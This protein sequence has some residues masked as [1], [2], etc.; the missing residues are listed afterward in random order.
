MVKFN[1]APKLRASTQFL[2]EQAYTINCMQRFSG[3]LI[4]CIVTNS[5]AQGL[6]SN[7]DSYLAGQE[8]LLLF[9]NP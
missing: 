1:A 9:G 7:I 2:P 5:V 6:T 4:P 3:A 8:T